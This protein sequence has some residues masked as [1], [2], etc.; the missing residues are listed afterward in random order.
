MKE[1]INMQI[2]GLDAVVTRDEWERDCVHWSYVADGSARADHLLENV[3]MRYGIGHYTFAEHG[4]DRISSAHI[5]YVHVEYEGIPGSFVYAN[6]Y[7]ET[8]GGRYC[9]FPEGKCDYFLTAESQAKVDALPEEDRK[10]V[11]DMVRI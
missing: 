9:Y 11:P 4:E 6:V 3:L 5:Y 8:D 10:L 7:L 2:N 1:K